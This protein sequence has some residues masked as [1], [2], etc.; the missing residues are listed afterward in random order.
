MSAYVLGHLRCDV[1]ECR[2]YEQVELLGHEPR[3]PLPSGWRHY[4]IQNPLTRHIS[5]VSFHICPVH[6]WAL[7]EF[8]STERRMDY[9]K[10]LR[11]GE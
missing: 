6:N 11:I 5:S 7:M 4:S 2:N 3:R 1:P 9:V 8:D 10:S